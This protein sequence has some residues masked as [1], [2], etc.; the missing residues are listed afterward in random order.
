[1]PRSTFLPAALVA[2]AFATLSTAAM[3]D[4]ATWPSVGGREGEIDVDTSFVGAFGMAMPSPLESTWQRADTK[5]ATLGAG[6]AVGTLGPFFDCY[7]RVEGGLFQS[8]EERVESDTDALPRGFVFHPA[9][10]GGLVRGLVSANLV[11]TPRHTFGLF[12][13]GMLPLRLDLAKFSTLHLNLLGGGTTLEVLL[14]PPNEVLQLRYRARFFVGSGA[15]DGDRQSNAQLQATNL[16][17]LEASRWVLPWPVGLSVGPH[18][19]ADLNSYRNAAYAAAY[20]PAAPGVGVGERIQAQSVAIAVM[21]YVHLTDHVA[22]EGTYQR[23]VV[24]TNVAATET[25][26]ASLRTAF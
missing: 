9:D 19:E 15:Y 4:P 13:Q 10:K 3:A 25:W 20:G 17:R 5:L 26:A 1:M 7:A 24:G 2:V 22:F 16:L 12:L 23:T 21:P 18:V 11:K 14:T 6:Y 8:A